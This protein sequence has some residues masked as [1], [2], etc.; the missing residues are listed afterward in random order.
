[1]KRIW[2]SLVSL[3]VLV[4]GAH[5]QL[6]DFDPLGE[7]EY[8]RAA[9]MVRCAVELIEV[10]TVFLSEAVA[11]EAQTLPNDARQWKK[12]RELATKGEAKLLDCIVVQTKPGLPCRVGSNL[13]KIYATE[14]DPPP[15]PE[16][17]EKKDAAK[18]D[19][20]PKAVAPAPTPVAAVPQ[21]PVLPVAFD[22]GSVGCTVDM[23]P[24][25]GPTGDIVD[26]T[27]SVENV[28]DIGEE[29]LGT[30][31]DEKAEIALKMPKFHRMQVKTQVTVPDGHVILL[32]AASP[33]DAEGKTD[34]TR[35]VLVFAKVDIVTTA[36]RKKP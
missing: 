20:P 27:I 36:D 3:V 12:A 24:V 23:D 25:V 11:E 13:E 10:P 34:S 31:K 18:T 17:E 33:P 7:R 35:K 9:K 15:F 5:G 28:T 1:M 30:W 21:M 22:T 8:A 32:G 4:A 19:S 6:D 26:L 16:A 29:I 14:Y 2:I